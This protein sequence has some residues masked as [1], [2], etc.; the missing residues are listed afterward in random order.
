MRKRVRAIQ[1][2]EERKQESGCGSEIHGD[3]QKQ[4]HRRIE[5]L[6]RAHTK[7]ETATYGFL[8]KHFRHLGTV[9]RDKARQACTAALG[10]RCEGGLQ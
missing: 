6:P 1:K 9:V 10:E 3:I 7:R 2:E 8:L 5:T 4:T